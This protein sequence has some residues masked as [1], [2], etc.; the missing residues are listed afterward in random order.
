M[1]HRASGGNDY[2]ST[3]DVNTEMEYTKFASRFRVYVATQGGVSVR[4]R[5]T[6]PPPPFRVNMLCYNRDSSGNGYGAIA[7]TSSTYVFGSLL[8]WEVDVGGSTTIEKEVPE[9]GPDDL[10]A[11]IIHKWT[12]LP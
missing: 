1:G 10:L 7:F 12:E 3:F 5:N 6:N 4:G 11:Y 9:L 8:G 2:A